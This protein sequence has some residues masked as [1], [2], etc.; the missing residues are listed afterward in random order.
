V[1]RSHP[2][3]EGVRPNSSTLALDKQYRIFASLRVTGQKAS[4]SDTG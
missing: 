4:I 2:V 1:G 3:A